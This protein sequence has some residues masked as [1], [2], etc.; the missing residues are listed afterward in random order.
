MARITRA[1]SIRQPWAELV[2]RGLK[3]REYRARRTNIRERVYVYASLTPADSNSGWRKVGHAPGELPIGVIVGS[4]EIVGC[5]VDG[6]I[7]E[8]A[9]ELANPRRF[10]VPLKPK[11]QPQPGFWRPKF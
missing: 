7:D 4:V 2:L 11:N 10:R 3:R 5:R 1:L 9:Y 6:K 8:F